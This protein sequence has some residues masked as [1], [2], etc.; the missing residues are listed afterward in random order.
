MAV[1]GGDT[2]LVQDKDISNIIRTRLVADIGGTNIRLGLCNTGST[3]ITDIEKLQCSDFTSLESALLHYIKQHSNQQPI[4]EAC[5]AIAG[6]VD[7]D[8]V[9]MTNRDWSFTKSQL[10]QALNLQ[11][12]VVIN[13]FEAVA[14]AVPYLQHEEL[15]QI[16]GT[17]AVLGAPKLAIGPGTGLGVAIVVGNKNSTLVLSTEGGHATIAP[18]TRQEREIVAFHAA[19]DAEQLSPCREHFLSGRGLAAIYQA[20]GGSNQRQPSDISAHAVSNKDEQSSQAL[21]VFCG[22]LGSACGDQAVSSGTTGGVYIAGGMVKQFLPFLQQSDF[23]QRFENKGAMQPY[24]SRI[25]CYVIMRD[26]VALLGAAA[27]TIEG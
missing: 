13:D 3:E 11:V 12:L 16:G 19:Q 5:L 7:N 4:H 10:Q 14:H 27:I 6:P 24:L 18:Q 2:T 22:L 26:H 9:K 8:L 15:H 17:E 21:K 1:T 23:R 20:L 25:P